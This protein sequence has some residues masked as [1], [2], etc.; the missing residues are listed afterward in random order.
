[1]ITDL[2]VLEPDPDTCELTLTH[3]HEGVELDQ[4]REATGWELA[5]TDD[6]GT[7]SPPTA[8]ELRALGDL[9]AT[10]GR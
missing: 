3:L 7:T 8:E 4:V 2:G 5:V 9:L 6:L 10:Q 1:V